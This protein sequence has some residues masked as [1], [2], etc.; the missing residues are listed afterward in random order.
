MP[1]LSP[2]VP[3]AEAHSNSTTS[4]AKTVMDI[5]TNVEPTTSITASNA[6]VS[7]VR[8]TAELME[9]RPTVTSGSP[10]S[11]ARITKPSSRNVVIL[12]PPA[13][14]ALPPPMNI[15]TVAM[16]SDS[17]LTLPQSK[18]LSPPDRVTALAAMPDTSLS[19]QDNDPM[20]PAVP[21]SY[22]RNSTAATTNRN[23]EPQTVSRVWM[24]HIDGRRQPWNSSA[25]T[26]NPIAPTNTPTES[27][28]MTIAS[29]A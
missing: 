20:V 21:H 18:L 11:S 23:S 12:M 10:R 9:R 7:A 19:C 24:V 27:A 26:G 1:V 25:S 29:P 22:T 5:T 14:L 16:L 15:S 3:N 13:V 17:G 2:T 6:M 8:M 4:N 28:T